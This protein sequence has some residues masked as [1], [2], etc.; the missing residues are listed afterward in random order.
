MQ[1]SYQPSSTAAAMP[2]KQ[3]RRM[4]SP[5]A[6][7]ADETAPTRA[8]IRTVPLRRRRGARPADPA[9]DTAPGPTCLRR[10]LRAASGSAA[11]SR[12]LRL[13]L[14]YE[15]CGSFPS[16]P[17]PFRV[18]RFPTAG[19]SG[20]RRVPAGRR[21]RTSS[22]SAIPFRSDPGP[23]PTFLASAFLYPAPSPSHQPTQRRRPPPLPPRIRLRRP[24]R[25]RV[26]AEGPR[27]RHRGR[28]RGGGVG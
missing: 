1:W 26:L 23:P 6:G 18:I 24:R 25:R 14:L 10:T 3:H 11:G 5:D 20:S 16:H 17:A 28:G 4:L 9:R 27:C 19:S 13:R 12:Q 2:G 7:T 22:V 15:G 8:T 21:R